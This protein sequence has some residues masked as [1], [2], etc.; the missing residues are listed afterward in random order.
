ML[1]YTVFLDVL[2]QSKKHPKYGVLLIEICD[3]SNKSKNSEGKQYDLFGEY[4]VIVN[5]E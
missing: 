3:R 2:I 4:S 5:S 1:S